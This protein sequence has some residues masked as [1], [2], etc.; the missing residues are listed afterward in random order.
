MT[1][2]RRITRSSPRVSERTMN[3]RDVMFESLRGRR[4]FHSDVLSKDTST[5]SQPVALIVKRHNMVALL[6]ERQIPQALQC[7]VHRSLLVREIT[8]GKESLL[9]LALLLSLPNCR[10]RSLGFARWLYIMPV[11]R[12]L[13]WCPCRRLRR[14]GS[15]QDI[16][17]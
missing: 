6:H 2:V 9:L 17:Q 4:L 12:P 1:A 5:S 16:L 13:A 10:R 11:T 7:A 8:Q 14:T 3:R 15:T